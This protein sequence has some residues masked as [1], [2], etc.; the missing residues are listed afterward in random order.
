MSKK[1]KPVVKKNAPAQKPLKRAEIAG[2]GSL[3][4][5]LLGIA[6][7]TAVCMLPMLQN[8]F[9]N[10]D[11]EFYVINNN[12]LQ[13]PD[14]K[15]IFSEP[16][17][18]NYHPLTVL[19]LAFNYFLSGLDPFSYL[20]VNYLLHLINTLLVF[21]FIYLISNK[22]I[23]A[24]AFTSL[25][26]GIHPMH[27]ESVAWVSERKDV[28]YTLFFLLS[29]IRYWKFLETNRQKDRW[30]CFVLFFLSLLSKP[31][32]V[33]LPLVLLLLDYWKGRSFS[34]KLFTE[35]I[36]FFILSFLFG[37][38]TVK[39]QSADA[40]AGLNV[41]T[42]T[43]RLFFACY[44]LM[45][46]FVRFLV[47]YPL[48]TFH[49]YPA[50]GDLGLPVLL[51]PFFVAAMLFVFWKLRK[52]KI[53]VFGILFYVINLL[54][55]LQILSIGLTIVSE[56]YTYMPYV[57]I[58]FMISML[59][60]KRNLFPSKIIMGV[61]VIFIGIMAFF[62]FQQTRVWK[63]SDTL[64][65]NAIKY[66]PNAP[67]ARTN[68]ANYLS[69][70]ALSVKN[71]TEADEIY[72]RAFEDCRVALQ[73]K[74]NFA[75]A[76]ECRGLMYLDRGQIREAFAEADSLVLYAPKNKLG[77]DIRGTAWYKMGDNEKAFA[78]FNKCIELSPEHHRA[79]S[80]RGTVLLNYYKRYNEALADFNKAISIKPMPNYFLNRAICYFQMGNITMAKQEA[81][82]AQELGVK[83]PDNFKTQLQLN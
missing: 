59:M 41:Y 27:V 40:I 32:A 67:H 34:S 1:S 45:T 3:M 46:Y 79:I 53:V 16:V 43:D 17:V 63:N 51:S 11:D 50:S 33:I 10:W 54:L 48:S 23:F 73:V 24:A 55:V 22:N 31:A 5:W 69:K 76:Y 38:I 78:D 64:W 8:E 65:T 28:L 71:K 6:A 62:T 80:N 77:Y 70:I 83:I 21:R 18:G 12:L 30:I 44:V 9:T 36:P 75:P 15:G 81:L 13:G 66:Y 47:P 14:W 49:P 72:S 19:S 52:N 20:L 39:I 29:V 68:R 61:T 42:V 56:R 35:K 60:T 37:I 58:A 2:A 7:V 26:F 82:K 25:V 57:G 4:P 74:K